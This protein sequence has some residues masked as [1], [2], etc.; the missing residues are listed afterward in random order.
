MRSQVSRNAAFSAVFERQAAEMLAALDRGEHPRAE[1]ILAQLPGLTDEEAVRIVFEEACLRMERGEASVT[2]EF[3]ERFPQWSSPLGVLLECK[4]LLLAAARAEFPQAGDDLGD[5][6]LLSEIGRGALGRT[7]LASQPSLA[8]RL[9][10]LKLT[11]LGA[12]EHLCLARLQHMNIVPL[13]VEHVFPDRNIRVLGMP[14]LGGASLARILEFLAPVPHAQRTGNHLLE[15]LD[16]SAPPVLPEELTL[17]QAPGPFRKYLAQATFVESICWIGGCLADAL[18]YAHDRGLVHLDVKP[19]NV[20][21]AADGQPMLLD[22]HLARAPLVPGQPAPDRL[23]G[24]PHCLSPEQHAA[25]ESVR[26]GSPIRLR[27]DGRSDLYSLG[28][29]LYEALGGDVASGPVASGSSRR[30]LAQCNPRVTPGLSDI[31][32]KCLAQEAGARY[33]DAA[34]LALD[35]RRHLNHFPLRGVANRSLVERW[36]KWRRRSP[37]ALSR[38]GVWVGGTCSVLLAGA[39]LTLEFFQR[40]HQIRT[41]L[42]EG[43]EHQ[44]RHDYPA[45]VTS[46]QRGLALAEGWPGAEAQRR[47]LEI[48]L[49]RAQRLQNVAELHAMVNLLRFRYG[50]TPPE[51]GEA[52]TLFLRGRAIW[53]S[54]DRLLSSAGAPMDAAAERQ[55]RTDLTDLAT[56]LADVAAHQAPSD[57]A[58]SSGPLA[59]AVQL[60]REAEAQLGPSTAT[61]RDLWR[62]SRALGL[63]DAPTP[64]DSRTPP[65]TAWEHYDLGRSYLRSGEH[66]LAEGE[67]RRSIELRPEEF[68]PYFYHGICCYKLGR[69]SD[70]VAS[71]GTAIALAPRTAE[72][73]FNRALAYQALG[74][75]EEAIR[76]NASALDLDP[77][78]TA[79]ALNWGIALFRTGRPAEALAALERAEATASSP[80]VRGLIAYNVA[81][82]AIARKDLPAAR[83]SLKQAIEHGDTD[84]RDLYDRLGPP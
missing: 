72:C 27:V 30:P 14:Y 21:I 5:F 39:V 42:A 33:P 61:S 65:S 60:L 70:S 50:I 11:P 78:F 1:Q 54:R 67:F 73:Y 48:S 41:A 32:R 47:V 45:A 66:A 55:V 53:R 83:A 40:E 69:H 84:A 71:L 58:V 7:F 19:S 13:Y 9:M 37:S 59:D 10:V 36:H 80:R 76:D 68:W 31:V 15:A 49:Q 62:Y 63:V 26:W 29:L 23:G 52:R 79:A 28:Q 74:R 35:L 38:L 82:I 6:R 12:E 81:L 8:N 4:R 64:P 3:L 16:R 34:S 57:G 2:T 20:L 56:I 22:F 77:H 51:P 43:R 25:I 17:L 18:Q 24:T 46:F 44:G 75:D